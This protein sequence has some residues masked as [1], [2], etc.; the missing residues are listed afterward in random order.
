MILIIVIVWI[1]FNVLCPIFYGEIFE[2]VFIFLSGAYILKLIYYI[3]MM[4]RASI[5]ARKILSKVK[6]G[7]MFF[8]PA[9][10]NIYHSVVIPIYDE[11]I[12]L[13]TVTLSKLAEHSR[14][15]KQYLIFLAL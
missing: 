4:A 3:F 10:K 14:A 2:Q 1:S 8:L 6:S 15:K 12:E 9:E 13:L 7:S 5:H 11:G